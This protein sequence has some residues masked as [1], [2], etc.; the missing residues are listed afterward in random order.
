[1]GRKVIYVAGALI[2]DDH[3]K[4]RLNIDRAAAVGFEVSKLGAYPAIP[5]TNTGAWFIGTHTSELW[6]ELT[7]EFMRRCDA[8]ILV[9]GW[10]NSK[11]TRGE[12]EEAERLNIPVFDSIA[13]LAAWLADSEII[14]R[15]M[16]QFGLGACVGRNEQYPDKP[17]FVG[18]REKGEWKMFGAGATWDEAFAAVRKVKFQKANGSFVFEEG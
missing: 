5:H 2:A 8:V 1:M 10:E 6:Y 7:L 12:K 18:A 11:G 15:A 16:K 9:P 4:I 14:E 17:L 3:Y 13:G